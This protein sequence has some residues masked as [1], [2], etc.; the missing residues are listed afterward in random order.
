MR[1]EIEPKYLSEARKKVGNKS[2]GCLGAGKEEA[3]APGS[4]KASIPGL[5][6]LLLCSVKLSSLRIPLAK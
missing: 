5:A 6:P 3:T 1:M 4:D 2:P